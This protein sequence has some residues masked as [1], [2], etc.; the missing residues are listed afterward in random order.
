MSQVKMDSEDIAEI[1]NALTIINLV[2]GTINYHY[3]I[4]A[5]SNLATVREQV[6][7]IAKLLPVVKFE[8][9]K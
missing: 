7:R 9:G 5:E 2:T 4:K 3:P 8:G 1:R 6:K